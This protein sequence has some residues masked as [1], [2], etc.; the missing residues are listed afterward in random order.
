[1]FHV[2]DQVGELEVGRQGDVLVF[3]GDPFELSTRLL[4]VFVAGEEQKLE[5]KP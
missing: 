2:D 4:R 5:T 1:M 3:S